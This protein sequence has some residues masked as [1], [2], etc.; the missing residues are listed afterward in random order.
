[1]LCEP[2]IIVKLKENETPLMNN[3]KKT[4]IDENRIII[5]FETFENYVF[6]LREIYSE[7][8]K[9]NMDIKVSLFFFIL[10]YKK[11]KMQLFIVLL[12]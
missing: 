12:G 1:M 4:N 3:I 7:R 2:A 9:Q 5:D 11:Y 6:Q 10:V 8:L